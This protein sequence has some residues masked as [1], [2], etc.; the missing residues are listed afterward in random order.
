MSIYS[1][2]SKRTPMS[3]TN[4]TTSGSKSNSVSA[5]YSLTCILERR[6]KRKTINK[7]ERSSRMPPWNVRTVKLNSFIVQKSTG[8]WKS[9]TND[10]PS[11]NC[12]F[13]PNLQLLM[14]YLQKKTFTRKSLSYKRSKANTILVLSN[15]TINPWVHYIWTATPN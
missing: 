8:L 5:I 11:R 10:S 7:K 4:K 13:I 3:T 6:K 14:A 1:Q 12:L 2:M 9:I 15:T